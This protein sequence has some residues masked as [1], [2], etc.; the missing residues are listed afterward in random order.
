[1]RFYKKGENYGI[2]CIEYSVNPIVM[3]SMLGLLKRIA[4]DKKPPL[5]GLINLE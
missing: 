5:Q 1:M 3:Y 2:N 4:F